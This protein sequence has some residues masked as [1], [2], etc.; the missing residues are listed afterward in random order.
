[1]KIK[2]ENAR[3]RKLRGFPKMALTGFACLALVSSGFGQQT[4]VGAHGRLNVDGNKIID[5][6]GD[7]VTLH[8]MSLYCWNSQGTQFY[9][10]SA[11]NHLAQD[12]KCTV[13][14]IPI[15]PNAYRRNPTNEINKVKTVV[16]ACIA[17]GIYAVVDWHAMNGAQNDVASA[18]AF[19]STLAAAYGKTPNILFEPWNEPVQEPWTVIKAYHEAIIT[20]IRAIDP[21]SI[22]ICG[23]RHWDQECDEASQNPITIS[24]NI[25]YSIHFYAATHR[26]SLRDNGARA[27]K[28][29][30]ALFCTEY[31]TSSASGGGA[32]DPAE[33]QLWWDWLDANK[34]SCANWSVAALDEISAAFQ[35]G[36]SATGPWTDA[37]LK[38]SGLLVRDYLVRKAVSG[39]QEENPQNKN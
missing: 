15:L 21:D 9:N 37:M 13:I 8:G 17:N 38:P 30:V 2:I 23:S 27:L 6:H 7:P 24:T 14:R 25:A 31:G 26:Q 22:I 33:T 35:P 12:W 34:I 18:R 4:F 16:D 20:A 1:M 36:A 39:A 11:V 3:R 32:Y 5:Q 19:F 29:G 10:A 28:N